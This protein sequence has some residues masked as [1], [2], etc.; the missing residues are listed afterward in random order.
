MNFLFD[1]AAAALWGGDIAYDTDNI[2]AVLIDTTQYSVDKVNH[3]N[4]SDIPVGARVAFTSNLVNKTIIDRIINADDPIFL[5]V[6]GPESS[7]IAIFQDTG[8]HET[9]KLIFYVDTATGLPA[10]PN[11]LDI[12]IIFNVA[13]IATF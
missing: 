12:T 8:T 2:K 9:S 4:L 5:T 13:G 3:T 10:T 11:G 6:T 7:A 1:K